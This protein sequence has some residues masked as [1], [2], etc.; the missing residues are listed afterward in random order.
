MDL[1]EEMFL[2][3]HVAEVWAKVQNT[4]ENSVVYYKWTCGGCGE[5][6]T[7]DQENSLFTS[8]IHLDCGHETKT[9]DG[10]LGFALLLTLRK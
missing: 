5:R 6:V 7:S 4:P 9:V 3:S 8:F 2:D 10:N 1:I